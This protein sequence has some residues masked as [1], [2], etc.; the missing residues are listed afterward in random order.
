MAPLIPAI[1]GFGVSFGVLARSAG[2]DA[3]ATTAMSLTTFAGSAQ[4]AAVSILG[5]GGGV[6]AAV[7][8]AVLLNARYVALGVSVASVFRGPALRRLLESQLVIDESWA[9][10]TTAPGRFDRRLLLGAGAVCYLFWVLGTVVGVLGASALGDPT[11]LGL[12]AAFPALFL[13]LLVAQLRSRRA[14]L[15]AVGGALVALVLLPLTPLGVPIIAAA[16]VPLLGLR[17]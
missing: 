11:V 17:R 12:D 9:L 4:F 1:L 8:A 5:A 2:L 3:W 16:A 7:V 6:T 10:G 15:A 14:V 13:A